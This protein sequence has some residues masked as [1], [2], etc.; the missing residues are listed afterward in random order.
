MPSPIFVL[1]CAFVAAACIVA[2][3]SVA[4][5][6]AHWLRLGFGAVRSSATGRPV[7]D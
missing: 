2:A 3:I 6:V 5:H 7:W 4:I 1:V